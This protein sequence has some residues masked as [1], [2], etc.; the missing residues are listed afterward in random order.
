MLLGI[1]PRQIEKLLDLVLDPLHLFQ[2]RAE[3]LLEAALNL[4][5]P[6]ARASR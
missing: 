1:D 6:G 3:R 5:A 4:E 2:A